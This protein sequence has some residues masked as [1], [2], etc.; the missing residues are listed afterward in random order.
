MRLGVADMTVIDSLSIAFTG[1]KSNKKL[2]EH[3]YNLCPDVG[4][5]AE[6][7]ATKG[8]KGLEKINVKVGRPIKMMLAQRVNDLEEIKKKIEGDLVIEGKYDGERIQ[9][10]KTKDG[11]INL[12]SRR[13]DN[14]TSQFPDLVDHLT[15]GIKAKEFILE[16][17]I[18]AIDQEG[19]HLPFQTLMQR[20]RKHNVQEYIKKI[21][22][23]LK[24]FD[25]LYLDGKE[26]MSAPLTDRVNAITKV[27]KE[28]KN[29]KIAEKITSSKVEK[30]EEFFTQMLQEG[31]EGI[32]IKDPNGTYQAGTRGWNWIKW[33]KEYVEALTDTIDVV[34][35][36]GFYG[37]G[38]RSG[39]FGAL[40]CA[41]YDTKKDQFVSFCKLGTGFTDDTL[42]KLH[43][44][45]VPLISK[46]KPARAKVQNEMIPDVWFTPEL[47]VEISGAEI[48]KSPFHTAGIALRFPRYLRTREKKAEQATTLKEVKEMT[49]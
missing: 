41:I 30:V 5:I 22:V 2:I 15:S 43:T 12:F 29:L 18:L 27:V 3:A 46:K 45:L 39:V 6:I 7:M 8:L 36:G 24:V 17:E 16:G 1:E 10:H 34:V 21:P 11:T 13:L 9:A 23:M 33:K 44:T 32:I 48:T 49:K 35:I 38:R 25:I 28:S 20:R 26:L 14:N 42:Q 31:Y 37:K 40:L 19:N 47:V 4:L